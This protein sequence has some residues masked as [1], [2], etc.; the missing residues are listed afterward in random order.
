MIVMVFEF[1]VEP[2][3]CEAY[4]QEAADLRPCLA[5]IEGFVSV[6]LMFLPSVYTPCGTCNGARYNPETLAIRYRDKSIADILDMTVDKASEFFTELPAVVRALAALKQVGLGYLRLGQP[7]T[8]LS[9][10]EAQRIRLATE[11]Q[12]EQKGDTLYLLDE[13]T[14]GLHP[15]DV[16]KLTNQL[17][18]LVDAGNT[19]IVVEH[20]MDLVAA[21]DWVIDLGPGAGA[22]G[23]TIVAQGSPQT[24]AADKTSRTAPYLAKRLALK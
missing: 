23:G 13:P 10:G 8:E 22:E 4:L 17:Q 5:Q 18:S 3:E 1:D 24:V 14:T 7:A 20:D 21:A 12:R 2:Q 11:L 15:S 16:E 9:G 19:V 6:E